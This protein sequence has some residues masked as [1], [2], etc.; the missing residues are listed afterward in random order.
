MS[1]PQVSVIIPVYNTGKYIERCLKSIQAQTYKNIEI[2]FVDDGSTDDSGPLLD[3]LSSSLD[4][5]VVI[6][7]ENKG[8]S[9]ARRSGSMKAKGEYIMFL[10]SDDTLPLD[11]IEYM[12]GT[13]LKENLDAFYGIFN[14]VIDGK[15]NS[16]KPRDFEGVISGDQMLCNILN[17]DFTYLGG[18]C[19]SRR[20]LWDEDMFCKER[21]LPSEDLITN[22]KLAIKCNRVGVYNKQVYNY[23]LVESSLTSTG[24]YYKLVYFKNLYNQLKAILKKEEK[25]ELVFHE[26]RKKEI[27]DFSFL[28][29]DI[30]TKDEWYKHILSYDV[31][32][33]P[34]KTKILHTLLHWPWLLHLCVKSNRAVKRI[35]SRFAC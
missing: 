2:V 6:H 8:L 10:D 7:Q 19:F 24:R 22:V 9:G 1:H 32:N 28:I 20:N 12:V 33:Y 5:V 15:V 11:A 35:S 17:P 16:A 3:T 29:K 30:D 34:R 27:Y 23:Y 4:N 18:M 26:L 25:E 13:S 14:R 21:E 31:S